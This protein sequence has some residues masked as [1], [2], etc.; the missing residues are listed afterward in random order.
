MVKS[1]MVVSY[2]AERDIKIIE[3][4]KN[5]I[6]IEENFLVS[7]KKHYQKLNNTLFFN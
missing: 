1:L 4:Y 5:S 3:D 7:K 2:V 6:F